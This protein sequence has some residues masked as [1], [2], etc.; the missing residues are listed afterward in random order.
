MS[1]FWKRILKVRASTQ[2]PCQILTSDYQIKVLQIYIHTQNKYIIFCTRV[3]RVTLKISRTSMRCH[4]G[5]SRD[6]TLTN[7]LRN[8]CI[9]LKMPTQRENI[10]RNFEIQLQL[11]LEFRNEDMLRVNQQPKPQVD[12]QI[13]PVQDRV[14]LCG[15][16]KNLK[17][18]NKADNQDTLNETFHLIILQYLQTKKRMS[19]IC[20][21]GCLYKI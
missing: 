2:K 6:M 19:T 12:Q 9:Q 14:E 11:Q 7:M 10:I 8:T 3:A 1:K 4:N 21:K 18:K 17:H 13:L 20:H 5:K 16:I 15:I